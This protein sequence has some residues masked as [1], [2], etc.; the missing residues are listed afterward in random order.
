MFTSHTQHATQKNTRTLQ[1]VAL[2]L[3]M[4]M[5]LVLMGCNKPADPAVK[6][7]SEAS[8]TAASAAAPAG[9]AKAVEVGCPARKTIIA[10]IACP[11]GTTGVY[12]ST[13]V[14]DSSP[15]V[16][17]YPAPTTNKAEAC[18]P[19]AAASGNTSQAPPTK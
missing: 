15:E 5:S 17:A 3:F 13:Q 10:T 11:A 6:T 19:I 16:C 7:A 12:Q 1:R 9:T 8:S 2:G 14:F 4:S 18:K